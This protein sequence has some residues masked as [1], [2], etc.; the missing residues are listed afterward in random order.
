MKKKKMNGID[1]LKSFFV[2]GWGQ[3]NKNFK[4][5]YRERP[6]KYGRGMGRGRANA[7]HLNSPSLAYKAIHGNPPKKYIPGKTSHPQKT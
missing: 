4:N 3:S 6:G 2:T 7:T 1:K 5:S